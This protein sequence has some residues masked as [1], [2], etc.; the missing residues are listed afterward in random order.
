MGDMNYTV[1]DIPWV[2]SMYCVCTKQK[3]SP[4]YIVMF[5]TAYTLSPHSISPTELRTIYRGQHA[6]ILWVQML[7]TVGDIPWVAS[8]YC[9]CTKQ[10]CSPQYIV[11][12]HT[13]YTLS[14]HSISPTEL[15]TIYRGQHAYILWVQMLYTV[16]YTLY[17]VDD[18]L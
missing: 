4:Q 14:P 15:R 12:F 5:H 3:C 17:T 1:G 2:A 13:A 10:K 16:G 11:M 6:Y 18:T 8:M 7:Y 9:V